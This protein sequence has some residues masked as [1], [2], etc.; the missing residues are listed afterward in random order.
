[1]SLLKYTAGFAVVLSLTACGGGGGNAGTPSGSTAVPTGSGIAVAAKAP[2]LTLAMVDASGTSTNSISSSG[3]T[4]LKATLN[5]PSGN[6]L[7][8]QVVSV[9]GD[10]SKVIFPE[11]ETALTN[12]SGVATVKLARKDLVSTGAGS[13]TATY[14]YKVG[15]IDKYPDGSLLPSVDSV[16]ARYIGYQLSATNI[17]L[18]NMDAGASTLAAYGTRQVS[19]QANIDGVVSSKTPVQVSFSATCGQVSP[20]T[21]STNSSGLA[22]V[23]YTATDVTGT[24]LSTQGCSGKTVEISATTVGSGVLTK[25]LSILAAPATNLSFVSVTP[26]R[27]FL[28]NSGGVTQAV[29]EFKLVNAREE[30]LLG[31]NVQLTLKT[32][33]GGVPKASFGTVGNISA[34]TVTTNSDGKVSVPVFSGTVPTSV[35]VNAALVS[36]P[37]VQTD[38]AVL[39]I[40][41]GRPA[42]GQVSLSLDKFAIRGFDFDGGEASVTM[43]LADRQGNPV[44]D[45]TAVNF[46]TEGGVMIPPVCTTGSVPGNSQCT[47]KIR[48]QNP[49]PT[50]GLVSILA[51]TSGE[52][53]FV[54]ANFNNVYDCGE[55]FTD[56]GY[57][58]RDD[59]AT[60]N[61]VINTFVTGEFSVPRSPSS[62][63]CGTGATPTPQVGDGVWGAADV[64]KQAVLVFST[65]DFTIGSATW[66]SA[67]NAQWGGATVTTQLAV[68][69]ADLNG[70][71]AP[72]GSAIDVLVTDNS[73]KLPSDGG[74]PA[75]IG[76]CKLTGQSHTA[77]PNSL[78]PL[79]LSVYLKE[80]V[81]GDQVKITVTTAAGAKSLNFT[82]P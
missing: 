12:A 73:A 20:S 76:S 4:L 44:P 32:L 35:I 22:L 60:L 10:T 37:L 40:A 55:T 27:I 47:V 5:D 33:N 63:T 68:S 23:T 28:A 16:V 77:I 71:S 19:V 49:R 79:P 24:A 43:S 52:E 78:V 57:A 69:I 45:G 26:T 48:T 6:P 75:L 21:A 67:A 39:S 3:F 41:S 9:S 82:V 31:Q 66:T 17:T 14:S 80:C 18:S 58:Y 15:S 61:G 7:A 11:G 46:V 30:P 62:S 29:A 51:Y 56:L 72:T 42:Q 70:N 50:N 36:N 13:L 2:V 64:R 81:T 34:I 74:T 65:D 25:S 8:N 1:M 38:S 53:D 54:D 59:T